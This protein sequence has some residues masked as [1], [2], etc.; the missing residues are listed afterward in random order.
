MEEVVRIKRKK[1]KEKTNEK[2]SKKVLVIVGDVFA[3]IGT[4]IGM[5]LIGIYALMFICTHGPSKVARDLFVLSVRET[6][7]VGFLANMVCSKSQIA[8]IEE[9]NKVIEVG[10]VSDS[11]IGRAHV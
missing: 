10:G 4:T 8:A 6:S 7:A 9:A 2:K 5:L 1:K 11:K 3:V